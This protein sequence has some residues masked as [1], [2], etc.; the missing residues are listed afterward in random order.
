MSKPFR[1]VMFCL[2]LVLTA[3]VIYRAPARRSIRVKAPAMQVRPAVDWRL[4]NHAH[5]R[6][7]TRSQVRVS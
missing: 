6:P 4:Y 5:P 3:L 2:V 7:A 1:R